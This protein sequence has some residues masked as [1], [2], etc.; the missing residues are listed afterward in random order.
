MTFRC[1]IVMEIVDKL[2]STLPVEYEYNEIKNWN[3]SMVKESYTST[4]KNENVLSSPELMHIVTYTEEATGYVKNGRAYGMRL[5]EFF[6]AMVRVASAVETFEP[7]G[8]IGRIQQVYLAHKDFVEYR[9]Q[10]NLFRE[11]VNVYLEEASIIATY[12]GGYN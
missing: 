6:R 12:M 5:N 8:Q 11:D 9:D 7:T 3:E 10:Y 2:N 1:A 4:V